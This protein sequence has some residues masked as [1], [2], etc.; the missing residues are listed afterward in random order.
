MDGKTVRFI[1][2]REGA[3]D[4][5]DPNYV[6][7][8]L[9]GIHMRPNAPAHVEP[10]ASIADDV[11]EQLDIAMEN[12]ADTDAW[13]THPEIT[14]KHITQD[15][16]EQWRD[17]EVVTA[18]GA[19]TLEAVPGSQEIVLTLNEHYYEQDAVNFSKIVYE[20]TP[21]KPRQQAALQS[22]LLDYGRVQFSEGA[23]QSL[24]DKYEQLNSPDGGPG[25]LGFDHNHFGFQH[26][27]VRQVVAYAINSEEVANNVHPTRN[28]ADR[29]P[30][31]R[32]LVP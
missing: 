29:R 12:P 11:I 1:P 6:L 2:D 31:W 21:A 8:W 15:H 19:W 22:G 5:L 17:P 9:T 27:E 32:S 13:L 26:Q 18:N 16:L 3:Y 20:Y 25:V 10:I 4:H 7:G 14:N 28:E 24:P 23:I 30:R